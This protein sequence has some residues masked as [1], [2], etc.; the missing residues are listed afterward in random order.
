MDAASFSQEM[1]VPLAREYYREQR[2]KHVPRVTVHFD[3]ASIDG[4]NVVLETL[5]HF[6]LERMEHPP[7]GPDLAPS[8][9]FLFGYIKE[10]LKGNVFS[11]QDEPFSAIEPFVRKSLKASE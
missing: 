2:G 5:R 8:D 7:E 6:G 10:K 9:S 11:S 4:T 1:I 3:N